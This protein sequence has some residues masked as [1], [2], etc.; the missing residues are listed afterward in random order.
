MNPCRLPQASGAT[1]GARRTTFVLC[2]DDFGVKYFSKADAQHL[3]DAIQTHYDLTIG[4]QGTFYCGL[5]L[6]WHYVAGYVDVSMPGYVDRA[7]KKFNHS[8]PLRHQ[9]S[10]HKWIE[11]A[12]GSQKPQSPT[13]ESTAQPL[14]KQ[15]TTRIQAINGTF[16]YY[17]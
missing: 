13:P 15:G 16:M 12:Y 17:G 5:T 1:A 14:D 7:L 11:P 3:I 2:V 10:P 4:W 6:D 8:A 9:H